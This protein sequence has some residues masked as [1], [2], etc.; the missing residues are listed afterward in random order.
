MKGYE[1]QTVGESMQGTV[2]WQRTVKEMIWQNASS[3]TMS[4]EMTFIT[5]HIWFKDFVIVF[6][7][8]V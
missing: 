4:V 3:S 1:M 7:D 8:Q 5:S 2:H 6:I